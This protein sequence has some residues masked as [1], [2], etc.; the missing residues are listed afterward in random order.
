[1][2]GFKGDKWSSFLDIKR[3]MDERTCVKK[4]VNY[5]IKCDI[6]ELIFPK[7]VPYSC[8]ILCNFKK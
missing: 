8:P 4:S 5:S 6:Q 7:S 2:W 1:M 3:R